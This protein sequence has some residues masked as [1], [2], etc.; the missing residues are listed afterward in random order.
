[1]ITKRKLSDVLGI[2]LEGID[3][4]KPLSDAQFREVEQAFWEGQVLAIKGQRLQPDQFLAFARRFGRPE[5][6]VIDQFHY[7]GHPDILILSNR[8]EN[9]K[10]IGLADGGT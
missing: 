1:M 10:P 6:H 8:K 5:P 2:A 9:G 4:A 3:L 7:K